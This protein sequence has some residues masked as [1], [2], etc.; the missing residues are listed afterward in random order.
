[1]GVPKLP[2]RERTGSMRKTPNLKA[3]IGRITKGPMASNIALGNNGAFLFFRNGHE[4]HAIISDG[5]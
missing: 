5:T 1:M 3:E 2:T 4:L